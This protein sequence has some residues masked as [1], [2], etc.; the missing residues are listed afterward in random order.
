MLDLVIMDKGKIQAEICTKIM[1]GLAQLKEGK[2]KKK[3]KR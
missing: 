1:I 3:F 2:K